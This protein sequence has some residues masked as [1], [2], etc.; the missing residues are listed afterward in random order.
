MQGKTHALIGNLAVLA[1]T[2]HA[3]PVLLA[4]ATLGSLAPDIDK[5]GSLITTLPVIRWFTRPA[6]AAVSA[7]LRH[8]TGTH[9]LLALAALALGAWALQ[10]FRVFEDPKGFAAGCAV[11]LAGYLSHILADSLTIT[12][13]PFLWPYRT[14]EFSPLPKALRIRTGGRVEYFLVLVVLAGALMAVRA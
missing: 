2:H 7:A 11:F 4:A 10:T 5:T 14:H 3:A 9:S 13:V 1:L 6:S 12:G 8:R